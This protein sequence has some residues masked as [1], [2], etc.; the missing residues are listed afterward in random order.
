MG[1]AIEA[2]LDMIEAEK[3]KYKANGI[4]FYRPLAFMITDGQPTD[5]ERWKSAAQ[6]VREGEQKHKVAFFCVAVRDANM[7]TL[8]EIASPQRPP[9]KLDGLKFREFFLWLSRSVSGVSRSAPD[10]H[11]KLEDPRI[12]GW[13]SI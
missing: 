7:E 12:A 13:T 1:E 10:D 8:A 5:G 4:A 6:R 2:A 9:L 11:V 3:Q